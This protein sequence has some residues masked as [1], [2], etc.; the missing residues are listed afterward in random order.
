LAPGLWSG[1]PCNICGH[2]SGEPVVTC[3][4]T[5]PVAGCNCGLPV[6][7]V[8][9]APLARCR[10]CDGLGRLADAPCSDC[11]ASGYLPACLNCAAEPRDVF[12]APCCSGAC[13]EEWEVKDR[14][15]RREL[16]LPPNPRRAP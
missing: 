13:R 5:P 4:S 8:P 7:P 14:L 1:I 9:T 2:V 16:G 3:L 10:R 6:P 12:F 11:D 15:A